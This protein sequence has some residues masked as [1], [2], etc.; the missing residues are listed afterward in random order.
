MTERIV[1]AAVWT[2]GVAVSLAAPARHHN[3]IHALFNVGLHQRGDDVEGFLTSIGRFVCRYEALSIALAREQ[4][5]PRGH[6]RL[7]NGMQCLFSEDVW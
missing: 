7:A 4:V 2:R 1:A 3:I 5:T 6:E